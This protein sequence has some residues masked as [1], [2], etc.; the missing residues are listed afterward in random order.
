MTLEN[1]NVDIH[2]VFPINY[3]EKREKPIPYWLY[4]KWTPRIGQWG[5]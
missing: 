3:C 5:K 4:Q 1:E 2:H